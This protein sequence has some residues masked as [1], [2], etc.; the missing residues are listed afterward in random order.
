MRSFVPVGE[1]DPE[2]RD[3]LLDAVEQIVLAAGHRAVAFRAVAARLDVAPATVE[4]YF[5]N[6]DDMLVAAVRRHTRARL[7]HLRRMLRD[8]PDQPLRV[9]WEFGHDEM[10]AALM[11][12]FCAM[13]HQRGSVRAE[14]LRCMQQLRDAQLRALT[15][16]ADCGSIPPAALLILLTAV[17]SMMRMEEACG[18]VIGHREV[19]DVVERLLSMYEPSR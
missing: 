2:F 10:S 5:P 8:R 19:V 13:G 4:H 15:G 17:P 16:S 7:T 12:E 18:V 6:V 1:R 14:I 11:V 3:S 9:V